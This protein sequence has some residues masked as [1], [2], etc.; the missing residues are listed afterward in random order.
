MNAPLTD[1]YQVLEPEGFGPI[2]PWWQSRKVHIGTCDDDWH[3]FRAPR[4]PL[5]F[6]YSFFQAA[7]PKL[8]LPSYLKGGEVIRLK[9]LIPGGGELSFRLPDITPWAAFDFTDGR[10][11]KAR[12]NCDGLH[13]DLLQDTWRVDLTWR[14]WMPTCPQFWKINLYQSTFAEAAHLPFSTEEG[15]QEARK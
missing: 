11:V 2:S 3:K 4:P 5:D 14:A 6:K 7:H 10:Q 13:I 9:G 1:P 8:I 15:L 12:L